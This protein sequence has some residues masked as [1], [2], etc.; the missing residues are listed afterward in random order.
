MEYAL[1]V[2]NQENSKFI[3]L[4]CI[5]NKG[6]YIIFRKNNLK[7]NI[8]DR[9]YQTLINRGLYKNLNAG[10]SSLNSFALISRL[11][12]CITYT[13]CL[14][15]EI[16]H[17][18]P[19]NNISNENHIFNLLPVDENIHKIISNL[20]IKD[21]IK[22]SYQLIKNLKDS[23]QIKYYNTL[24]RNE[25]LIFEFLEIKTKNK[26]VSEIKKILN[27]KIQKSTLYKYYKYFYYAKEFLEW[28]ESININE[29][30]NDFGNLSKSWEFIK[31]YNAL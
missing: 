8:N 27:N 12:A 11:C 13:H 22:E 6:N 31:K 29:F 3:H 5:K 25:D 15:K 21:G 20:D 30:T 17:I 24:Q 23:E 10:L 9:L 7:N 4:N 28:L 16:H 14:N 18:N 26:T 19:I 2:E 1:I